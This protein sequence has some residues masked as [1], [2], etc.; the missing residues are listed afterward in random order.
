MAKSLWCLLG[1]RTGLD[2]D[3]AAFLN[4]RNRQA[5]C[6]GVSE[7]AADQPR[8]ASPVAASIAYSA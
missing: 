1:T 4:V 5:Q 3:R 6:R 2:Q 7:L 8:V